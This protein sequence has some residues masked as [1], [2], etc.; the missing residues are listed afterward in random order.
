[1]HED[2][3]HT[4]SLFIVPNGIRPASEIV[5][6]EFLLNIGT[7]LPSTLLS[8]GILVNDHHFSQVAHV[9]HDTVSTANDLIYFCKGWEG[10][11]LIAR[12]SAMVELLCPGS[13]KVQGTSRGFIDLHQVNISIKGR[14][15]GRT[16]FVEAKFRI[17]YLEVSLDCFTVLN[18]IG[19]QLRRV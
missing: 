1:L 12:A 8:Q 17:E 19:R 13:R 3:T 15:E 11:V 14:G 4:T 6:L 7:R 16:D 5:V 2:S 18:I 10:L 9:F